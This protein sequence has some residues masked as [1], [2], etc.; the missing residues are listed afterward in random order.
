MPAPSHFR[1][2]SRH[3]LF[4]ILNKFLIFVHEHVDNVDNSLGTRQP[5]QT[6]C[7]ILL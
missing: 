7:K 2:K 4:K 1:K 5:P 3:R 6:Y